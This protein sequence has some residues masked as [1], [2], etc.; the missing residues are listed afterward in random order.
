[1]EDR[2]R[3]PKKVPND[4]AIWIDVWFPSHKEARRWDRRI[5]EVTIVEPC[6]GFDREAFHPTH[7]PER[8]RKKR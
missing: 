3:G 5:V 6:E 2:G 8:K 4:C 1:M 7:P